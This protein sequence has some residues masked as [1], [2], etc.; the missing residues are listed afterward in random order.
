MRNL[1]LLIKAALLDF[2]KRS[3]TLKVF[4]DGILTTILKKEKD[5]PRQPCI[6]AGNIWNTKS[7]FMEEE[8]IGKRYL[9]D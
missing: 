4:S 6:A 7:P 9:I 2:Q 1:S 8:T 5:I 3:Q